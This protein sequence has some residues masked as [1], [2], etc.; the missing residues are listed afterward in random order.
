MGY[1]ELQ[2]RCDRCIR[3]NLTCTEPQINRNTRGP[4]KP[5][6]DTVLFEYTQIHMDE[7]RILRLAPGSFDDPIECE[8]IVMTFEEAAATGYE[9][10]SYV[11]G[12]D[13][14]TETITLMTTHE[15]GLE[16]GRNRKHWKFHIRP[17]PCSALKHLRLGPKRSY[18][19]S[20]DEDK[21]Y[22]D[23]WI[24]VVCINQADDVEKAQQFSR[25]PSIYQAAKNVCVWL[26]EATES[27]S[28]AFE[29]VPKLLG[30]TFENLLAADGNAVQQWYALSQVM[31]NKWFTRRWVVS[32]VAFARTA[33]LHCGSMTLGWRDFEDA[34]TL[35]QQSFNDIKE[36]FKR[37][38]DFNNDSE[39]VGIV[40]ALPACCVVNTVSNAFQNK[41]T[42]GKHSEG[43]KSL[44]ALVIA[45]RH[46][47]ATD[48]R[49]IIYS[50]MPMAK[51]IA[52]GA[53][54]PSTPSIVI[55]NGHQ[56][57][58]ID[59]GISVVPLFRNFVAFAV[60][61]SESLD[62]ICR[63]WAPV[64][65]HPLELPSWIQSV[66]KSE[67]TQR[68]DNFFARINADSLVGE[69]GTRV[70]N[71][72]DSTLPAVSFNRVLSPALVERLLESCSVSLTNFSLEVAPELLGTGSN[73]AEETEGQYDP[74]TKVDNSEVMYAGGFCYDRVD[75]VAAHAIQGIIP[76]RWLQ[77]G[78]LPKGDSL[79][80]ASIDEAFWRTLVANR[81][82]D[83]TLP[84]SY[85]PRAYL[86]CLGQ[87]YG[88]HLNVNELLLKTRT[89]S[90]V[91]EFLERVQS[92]VWNRALFR[93]TAT[94][95][96]GLT[97]AEAQTGDMIC[98]LFGCSVP[99]LLRPRPVSTPTTYEFLGECYV[100]GIMDGEAMREE[101]ESKRFVQLFRIY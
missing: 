76:R 50:L 4:N 59:Y 54:R 28:T 8:L 33:T 31:R 39:A 9:A 64:S 1:S 79:S 42:S 10:L 86:S 17:N 58:A 85:Y 23:L 13:M 84:P 98:I 32:D 34:V 80:M 71:A 20:G 43:Q 67:F 52:D 73:Y 56:A 51:D 69:P 57:L 45:L 101:R 2:Q 6:G 11:W 74:G 22:R 14:S 49:D 65:M 35:F 96:F 93:T 63:P 47:N 12:N 99:V 3:L 61:S 77:L 68:S 55:G 94:N 27:T 19:Q 81:R 29:F 60:N 78:G 16:S 5:K 48:E 53:S 95:R 83:G 44:E 36:L 75:T 97:S 24:D 18:T 15:L 92:V 41:D 21:N 100:H 88:G 72:A 37:S 30:A 46:L 7:I 90:V 87:S 40:K 66:D 70:Y 25:M 91:A 38:A 26:G 89:H 62:I 82:L